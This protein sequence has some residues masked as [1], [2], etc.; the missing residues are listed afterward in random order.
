MSSLGDNLCFLSWTRKC[1]PWSSS[2][3]L[4]H[5]NS[6]YIPD[7]KKGLT[8][9]FVS[10]FTIVSGSPWIPVRKWALSSQDLVFSMG[11]FFFFLLWSESREKWHGVLSVQ[12]TGEDKVL[13]L[14]R[15]AG[16]HLSIGASKVWRKNDTFL[17]HTHENIV[18]RLACNL[19]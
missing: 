4:S 12:D 15:K 16:A 9:M 1:H 5:L 7:F 8:Y 19:C 2:S 3:E 11:F 13:S 17:G 14:P 18:S 6:L 10:L